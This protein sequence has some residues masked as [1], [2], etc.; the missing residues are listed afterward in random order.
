MQNAIELQNVS[1]RYSDFYLDN[2]SLQLPVGQVMGLVGVNGAGK[3]TTLRL[4]MGL[5]Q[6]DTGSVDVLGY[7][8]PEQQVLAKQNI[9]FASDDMRLYKTENLRWH[10]QLIQSIFP[11]WDATYAEHLL[12]VFD[13]NAEQKFKGFSH[14]QRVKACL[15][16]ILARKPNLVILDEPT[17]GLDPV[18]REE[19]LSE[20]AE[21]LRDENRSVLFSSHNTQDI[22]Q[23]SDS[24]TFLHKG[25]LLDSQDK[26]TYLDRWRRIV[27]TGD[28]N[29]AGLGI[30][31]ITD[32]KRNGS[33]NEIIV[34]QYDDSIPER[35]SALGLSVSS[36]DRMSL[37]KIFVANVRAG[38]KA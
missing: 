34:N 1:K 22:E 11:S 24:I 35:L 19:V 14:G 32:I 17:T 5:I 4:L 28:I 6:P 2:L 38:A 36:V 12:N 15:L 16:L 31:C 18:A 7:R 20:L 21:I 13:L 27:C 10:M 8:L 26:E 29:S 33:L 3:S 30:D 37:E 25:K 23:L 9:G